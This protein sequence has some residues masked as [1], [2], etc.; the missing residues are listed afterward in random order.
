MPSSRPRPAGVRFCLDA[1]LSYRVV[2]AVD[3]GIADM[4]HVSRVAMLASSVRGRSDVPD[5]AVARW[6]AEHERVLVTCDDDYRGR[7][8]RTRALANLGLEVIVFVYELSGLETQVD[9]IR[10]RI[11]QWQQHLAG[12]PYGP[13]VWLEYR[14]G[15]LRRARQA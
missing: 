7:T 10:R 3:P 4:I 2:D 12:V 8:A 11:P 13:R 15:S 9:T 1:N 14:R 5:Q 6:C